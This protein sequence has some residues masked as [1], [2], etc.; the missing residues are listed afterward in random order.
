MK[1]N[2]IDGLLSPN[3]YCCND[4]TSGSRNGGD[5]EDVEA[6]PGGSM[7]LFLLNLESVVIQGEEMEPRCDLERRLDTDAGEHEDAVE[8]DESSRGGGGNSV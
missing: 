2:L 7:E 1:D 8:V 6:K 3:E 5:V 4:G